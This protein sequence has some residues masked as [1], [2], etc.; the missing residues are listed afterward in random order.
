MQPVS[1]TSL[2]RPREA[3][4][5]LRISERNLWTITQRGELSVVRFGRSVRYALSDL[6]AFAESHKSR[7]GE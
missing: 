4:Q 6:I 1:E 3:A 7:A 5:W 2:L